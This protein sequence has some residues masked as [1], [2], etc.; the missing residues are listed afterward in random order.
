MKNLS[1]SNLLACCIL[2]MA[3]YAQA[4]EWSF[5]P[6]AY[7]GLSARRGLA[8]TSIG[9]VNVFSSVMGDVSGG[10][11]GAFARYDRP[12]WYG[13]IEVAQGKYNLGGASVSTTGQASSLFINRRRYD[14]RLIGGYKPLPWLRLHGGL[15]G[16]ANTSLPVSGYE[17]TI[18]F[19]KERV[20]NETNPDFLNRYQQDLAFNQVSQAVTQAYEKYNLEGQLGLGVDIGGLTVDLVFSQSLTPNVNGIQLDGITYPFRQSYS[21]TALNLGYKLFPLK[22]YLLALGKNNRAYQR[23]KQDIPFYRNE[24]QVAAGLLTEDIGSA[25]VYENRYTRYVSRRVGLTASVGLMRSFQGP[26][27]YLPEATNIIMASASFRLLALYS[28]RHT[29]GL[30]PGLNFMSY[31]GFRTNSGRV[32]GQNVTSV[33]I[34]PQNYRNENGVGWQV[35]GDYTFALTDRIPIG[36]WLR[37]ADNSAHGSFGQA[38]LQLGYRF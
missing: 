5:G 2:I 32:D 4:Q 24:V 9:A 3:S 6:K 20:A 29:I 16:V 23:I 38:G 11:I 34:N 17:S 12:R 36:V 1:K 25:S 28:R 19:L 27:R 33:S 26:G 35:T 37:I 13:Q 21:Y 18:A 31:Q 10:G 8:E 22:S 7:L 30:S 15:V 14:L